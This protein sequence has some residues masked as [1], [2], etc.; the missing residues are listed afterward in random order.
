MKLKIL[1]GIF[2]I[3]SSSLVAA[4]SDMMV[5]GM[6]SGMYG[7]GMS[8]FMLLYFALFAFIFSLIFWHTYKLVVKKK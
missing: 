7:Y 6:M 5:G 1:V 3:L 8:L 4:D 2:S